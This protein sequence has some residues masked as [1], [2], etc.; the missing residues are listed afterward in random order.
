MRILGATVPT[1]VATPSV[2]PM[3]PAVERALEMTVAAAREAGIPVGVCGEM[4]STFEGRQRLVSLG[5][6][7]VSL[8]SPKQ[9]KKLKQK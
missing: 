6:D 9:I 3:D 7:S 1:V 8:S 5:V 4:A 2:N